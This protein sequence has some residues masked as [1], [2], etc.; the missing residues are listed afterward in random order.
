M[1]RELATIPPTAA[2]RRSWRQ[3]RPEPVP[4]D[5]LGDLRDLCANFRIPPR[6]FRKGFDGRK[7]CIGCYFPSSDIVAVDLCLANLAWAGVE[8]RGTTPSSCMNFSMP[9]P[10]E[11]PRSGDDSGRALD[12]R[13][14]TRRRNHARS[15]ANRARRTRIPGGRGRLV[16]APSDPSRSDGRGAIVDWAAREA[17]AWVLR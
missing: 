3:E 16:C 15:A 6:R 1:S 2:T 7:A 13:L 17:A 4:L 12:L 10:S 8:M 11:S 14:R 5:V 9:R